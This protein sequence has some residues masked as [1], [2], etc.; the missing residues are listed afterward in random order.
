M[1]TIKDVAKIAGVSTATVSRVINNRGPLS[2][3]TIDKVNQAMAEL[4]YK[5]N[6]LARSLVKGKHNCIGVI[7]PNISSPFWAQIAH[8][9]EKAAAG[10]GYSIMIT[11]ASDDEQSY[12]EKFEYLT[13][14]MPEGIITS[15]VNHTE[16]YIDQ[17]QIPVVII[18]N[19]DYTPSVASNDEQGGTLAT[20]HLIAKGC[21]SLIH[22]GGDLNGKSSGNARS[23]AFIRE[24]EK[25]KLPYKVYQLSR[26]QQKELDFSGV[27]SEIFCE[28]AD[29]D[30]IFASNDILAA[31]CVSTALSLG[32]RIPEDIRIIGYDDI[33]ISPLIYPPLST[34]HQDIRKLAQASVDMLLDLSEGKAADTR[35]VLPVQ[36]I[37]RKTT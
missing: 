5:P 20:R 29:F 13:A 24:C 25:H 19:S 30:G 37:E 32:Y 22:I 4:K 16:E 8:E 17:S 26:E 11:V 12:C 3:K 35:Q 2:Q 9:L 10:R 27:I 28:D 18:G 21:K 34:I 33:N 1:T 14:S 7:L 31:Y 15:Y 36:L 23:F 6:T